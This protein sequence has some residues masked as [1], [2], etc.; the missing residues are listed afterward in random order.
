LQGDDASAAADPPCGAR[1]RRAGHDRLRRAQQQGYFKREG[2]KVE[3]VEAAGGAAIQP[4]IQSG[5][6]DLGWSN[7]VS[8]V[9]AKSR[10]LDFEFL[11]GGAFL[12][13]RH[14]K[15]QAVLV[16]RARRSPTR[17]SSRARRSA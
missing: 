4:A 15:N 13:P 7:V 17:A 3:Q 2:L 12:G 10:N 11:G 14:Y 6:L 9:L 5:D 8:V 1:D 16:K